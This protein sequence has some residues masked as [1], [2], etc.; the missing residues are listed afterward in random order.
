MINT[1]IL[2]E[3]ISDNILSDGFLFW[4]QWI[5]YMLNNYDEWHRK[6]CDW[7]SLNIDVI[8]FIMT[9]RKTYSGD[10][11]FMCMRFLHIHNF[12]M[13]IFEHGKNRKYVCS[14]PISTLTYSTLNILLH[15]PY[16]LSF[17]LFIIQTLLFYIF[18]KIV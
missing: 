2:V 16:Y 13:K 11:A 8:F 14:T 4:L 5:F 9:I 10:Y 15:L 7:K 17:H 18:L 3:S 1:D 6:R 12:I